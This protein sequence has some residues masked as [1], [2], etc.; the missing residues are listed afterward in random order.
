MPRHQLIEEALTR[1]AIGVFYRVYD[2]LGYGFLEHVYVPA[3]VREFT[4]LGHQVGREVAV[5]VYYEGDVIAQQRLDLLVDERLVIEV[6][7]TATL[8]P[9]ARRQ[10]YNYLR[11]TNL[12]VGLLFHF[13]PRARFYREVCEH[14]AGSASSALSASSAVRSVSVPDA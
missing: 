5:N 3:V 14:G 10:L 9:S 11:S 13:G 12:R 7:A 1:S 2:H 4:K 8:H 6:K